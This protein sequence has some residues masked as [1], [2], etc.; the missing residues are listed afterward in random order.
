MGPSSEQALLAR[1]RG[2]YERGL[3]RR[4]ARVAGF[5][6]PMIGTSLLCCDHR[7]LSLVAGTLL[8]AVAIAFQWRGGDWG[9][10]VGPGLL[11]GVVALLL[12]VVTRE[13]CAIG[14]LDC[15]RYCWPACI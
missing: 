6:L 7:A 10:A 3:L 13:V 11:S 9:R 15:A 8:L 5:V 4:A 12:P 1:A 14:A 2:A